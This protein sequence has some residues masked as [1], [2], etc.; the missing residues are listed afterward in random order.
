MDSV[1]LPRFQSGM[2]P[3]IDFISLDSR[4]S[5][6]NSWCHTLYDTVQSICYV[7]HEMSQGFVYQFPTLQGT[8]SIHIFSIFWLIKPS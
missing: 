5:V 3:T 6:M 4:C 2:N 7:S 1:V 8:R